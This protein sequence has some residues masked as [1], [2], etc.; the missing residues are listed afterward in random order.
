[1]TL[2]AVGLLVVSAPIYCVGIGSGDPV[3]IAAF[4]SLAIVV[5]ILGALAA[6]RPGTVGRTP[7]GPVDGRTAGL[8][9][10]MR[11]RSGQ[12]TVSAGTEDGP[13]MDAD[14]GPRTREV[15]QD[16]PNAAC[17]DGDVA[18]QAAF[19]QRTARCAADSTSSTGRGR[20]SPGWVAYV[21]LTN[22]GLLV[23]AVVLCGLGL[24]TPGTIVA[25]PLVALM[26]ALGIG[27]G[28]RMGGLS[29]AAG[30]ATGG[31]CPSET[32]G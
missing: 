11:C 22:A 26:P 24:R 10:E 21:A 6:N 13:A 17:E 30:G 4:V 7:R 20:R 2:V 23:A 19:A 31:G 27:I 28:I 8:P 15:R 12:R 25:A 32:D 16:P 1:V 18:A 9:S 29:D 14:R 3:V 5:L